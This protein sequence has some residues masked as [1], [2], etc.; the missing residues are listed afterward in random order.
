MRID[1]VRVDRFGILAEQEIEALS[2]GCNIFLGH[3]EA[4]KSTTMAFFRAMLFGYKRGMSSLDPFMAQSRKAS[5]AGGSLFMHSATAGDITLVRRPLA[6][7]KGVEIFRAGGEQL[8]EEE[9]YALLGSITPD[10]YDNVFAFNLRSLMDATSLDG[11]GVRH[12]L[13]A[14]AFGLKVAPGAALK[15]LGKRADDFLSA[16]QQNFSRLAGVLG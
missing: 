11:E 15:Q 14:A 6:R 5:V 12:A 13:H 16:H 4:G 10:V 1:R 8:T 9:F 3:N 2:P 7:G